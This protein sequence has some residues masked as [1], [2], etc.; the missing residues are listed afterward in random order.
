MPTPSSPCCLTAD[1]DYAMFAMITS[2]HF[3]ALTMQ[4]TRVLLSQRMYKVIQKDACL[5]AKRSGQ[6]KTGATL[7]QIEQQLLTMTL[8]MTTAS[9]SLSL[10]YRLPPSTTIYSPQANGILDK[11]TA[12]QY[13]PEV[14]LHLCRTNDLLTIFTIETLTEQPGKTLL[15]GMT[16][17]SNSYPVHSSST[18]HPVPRSLLSADSSTINTGMGEIDRRISLSRKRKDKLLD[19]AY[20]VSSRTLK[21]THSRVAQTKSLQ[22][23]VTKL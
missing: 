7:S 18:K 11:R 3:N 10:K 14:L 16:T 1:N 4:S 5:E 19:N 6:Q 21:N 8:S 22:L 12:L 23:Y 15:S 2:S 9:G 13:H 20:F 17:L